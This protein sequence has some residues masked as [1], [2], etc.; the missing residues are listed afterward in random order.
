MKLAEISFGILSMNGLPIDTGENLVVAVHP[1]FE[2][3][4]GER[5]KQE[6]M[7][8]LDKFFSS[9]RGPIITLE[10]EMNVRKTASHY[11]SL[12]REHNSFFCKYKRMGSSSRY[13]R[14]G[15]CFKLH[16]SN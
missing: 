15:Y 16:K 6:Y 14:L 7:D 12:G 1:F 5:Y 2:L 13:S 8:R 9:R 10:E 3:Y 4:T 11:N